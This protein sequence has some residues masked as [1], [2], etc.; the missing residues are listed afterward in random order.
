MESFKILR[1]I[2]KAITIPAHDI[3]VSVESKTFKISF[4]ITLSKIYCL[5]TLFYLASFSSFDT[6]DDFVNYSNDPQLLT[7]DNAQSGTNFWDAINFGAF[8]YN[9]SS[10][11]SHE[12]TYEC[13]NITYQVNCL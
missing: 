5:N 10:M 11:Y 9:S 6:M 3:S 7:D 2:R 8:N 4:L 13:N 1:A 12:S